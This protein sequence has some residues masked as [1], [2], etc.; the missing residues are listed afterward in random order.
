M[1]ATA[2]VDP[3]LS[4]R[5]AAFDARFRELETLRRRTEAELALLISD[6]ERTQIYV[7]DGHANVGGWCRT[8]GRWSTKRTSEYRRLARL[9][10]DIPEFAHA[11]TAGTIGSDQL[12]LLANARSNP[13]C[14]DEL[15][16]YAAA[17]LDSARNLPLEMFRQV[18]NRWE[19]LHDPDGAHRDHEQVHTNRNAVAFALDHSVTFHAHGGTLQGAEMKEIFDRQCKAEFDSDWAETK[20]RYGDEACPA[21]MPRT[22]A[23]RRFDA[24]YRIFLDAASTP[25]GSQA[26]EPVVHI[27]IDL[28]TFEAAVARMLGTEAAARIFDHR[29]RT[30]R[31][32]SRDPRHQRCETSDGIPLDPYQIVAAALI[33]QVRR[34]VFDSAGVAIDM[35]HKRRLFTGAARDAVRLSTSRCL[36]PGCLLPS[37]RCHTDHN[38]DFSKGG[39][40]DQHNGGPLCHRHNLWKNRG[41]TVWRDP[42]GYW[43]T[44]RPDGTEIC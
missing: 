3:E 13:R 36:W 39:P 23:Q 26:P 20:A 17:L 5:R 16:A 24:F 25:P 4:A 40:T 28:D 21:L 6:A 7:E 44:Y 22:D 19:T 38:T 32:R 18:V 34:I 42:N 43:H 14:G 27:A 10:R 9:L 29:P 30:E 2:T 11:A 1:F 15:G 35:G 33:G 31:R 41:Y 8:L 12:A 37:G